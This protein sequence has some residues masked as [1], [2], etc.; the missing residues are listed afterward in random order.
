LGARGGAGGARGRYAEAEQLLQPVARALQ[1]AGD[2]NDPDPLDAG[3]LYAITLSDLERFDDGERELRRLI[4]DST[5]VRGTD[6]P[7][8]IRLRNSLAVLFLQAKRYPDAE[9]VLK[10]LIPAAERTFGPDHSATL[11]S[12]SNLGGALRQQGKVEESGPYYRRA[13]EQLA[14]KLG[15]KHP[16]AIMSR[17]N[18]GNYLLDAG[19]AQA[20]LDTQKQVLEYANETFTADHPVKAEILEGWGKAA[21]ALGRYDE[22]EAKLLESLAL[23]KKLYGDKHRTLDNVNAALAALYAKSGR[24]PPPSSP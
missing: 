20:S 6:H 10:E 3:Y 19:D 1:S 12:V 14:A 22:A 16:R 8:T 18:L 17:H 4:A 7:K 13:A 21:T 2:A 9:V 5:R 15:P 11:G 23:K 24:G